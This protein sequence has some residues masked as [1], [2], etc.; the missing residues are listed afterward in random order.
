VL[1]NEYPN[2]QTCPVEEVFDPFDPA[3]LADPYPFL[4]AVRAKE[5]ICLGAPPAR[6]QVRIVL[7]LLSQRLPSLRLMPDQELRFSPNISFRGP[8]HLWVEWDG[9]QSKGI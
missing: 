5:P 8:E 2:V 4:A 1:E 9:R 7:E 3:Y 6:M